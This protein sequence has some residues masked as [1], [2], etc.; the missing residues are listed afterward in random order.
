MLGAEI[1]VSTPKTKREIKEA[2]KVRHPFLN[3][4]I[5]E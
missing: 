2:F 1:T 5:I 4:K 3:T